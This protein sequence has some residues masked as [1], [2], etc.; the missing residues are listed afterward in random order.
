MVYFHRYIMDDN[1]SDES[2]N[3]LVEIFEV[4]YDFLTNFVRNNYEN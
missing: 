2:K 3:L 1:Y 4:V